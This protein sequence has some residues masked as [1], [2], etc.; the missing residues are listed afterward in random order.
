MFK[1]CIC[2]FMLLLYND[3]GFGFVI[4]SVVLA[5]DVG[6]SESVCLITCS[7]GVLG[8]FLGLL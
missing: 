6:V 1:D 2:Y 7:L 5:V 3:T 4:S 8:W